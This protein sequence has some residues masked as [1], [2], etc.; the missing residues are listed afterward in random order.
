[1]T[2]EQKARVEIDK[3]LIAAGWILQDKREFNPAA[4]VG[5]AVREFST[6][7]G[8]VDYL[9]FIDRKPVGVIEAKKAEEG[10]S[11]IVHEAQSQRYAVSG[12]KWAINGVNIRFAYE[13][14]DVITRFTDYADI[15]T[16]SRDVYTFH[17]PETLKAF[18]QPVERRER[19][20]RAK[21]WEML[22][23]DV[24][25]TGSQIDRD[26]VNE[27]QI[28]TVIRTF[29]DKLLTDIFPGR[30]ESECYLF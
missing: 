25:Y 2:P 24:T 27:S 10:Q 28:R 23:E 29:R 11:I 9:L 21:R 22:D 3:R 15:K 1:M 12:I 4:S 20:T 8:P 14:T 30:R 7:T 16:R 19:L 26:V 5:V 6:D 18:G 13:A 17:H